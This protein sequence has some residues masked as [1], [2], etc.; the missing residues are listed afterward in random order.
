MVVADEPHWSGRAAQ[1]LT[2]L[3]ELLADVHSWSVLRTACAAREWPVGEI[4]P[5]VAAW[6]DDGAFS[7]W[8]VGAFPPIEQLA[9][10]A[11]E[12][13]RPSVGRRLQ[14]ALRAWQLSVGSS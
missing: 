9:A 1:S 10:A 5:D 8:V 6:L 4:P 11:R 3:G 2:R 13:V 7:R 12:L 14:A